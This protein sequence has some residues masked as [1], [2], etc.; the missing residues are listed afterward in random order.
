M[1]LF[2]GPNPDDVIGVLT[3]DYKAIKTNPNGIG[4]RWYHMY[5]APKG[6][7]SE[8][9]NDMNMGWADGV[10]YRGSVMLST[11]VE[12][13]DEPKNE[14]NPVQWKDSFEIPVYVVILFVYII[15]FLCNPNPI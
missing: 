3:F 7:N 1:C 8:L 4:N 13:C 2:Q 9:A 10:W 6:E 5:G 11:Q 12:Q 14:A 15:Y